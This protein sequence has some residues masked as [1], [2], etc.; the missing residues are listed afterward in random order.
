MAVG[1]LI[2]LI[3]DEGTDWKS[4]KIPEDVVQE[5][6]QKP[7]IQAPIETHSVKRYL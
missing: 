7:Q 6:S 2:A 5:S 1:T 4:I 3:A